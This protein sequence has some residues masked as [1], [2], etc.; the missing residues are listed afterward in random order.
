VETRI[1]LFSVGVTD[2][3]AI[4]AALLSSIGLGWNLYRDLRDKAKLKVTASVKRRV[5]CADGKHYA[6]S[7]HINVAGASDQLFVVI[8]VTNVGRRPVSWIGWGGKYCVPQNMKDSFV[9]IPIGLPRTL[10]EGEFHSEYTENLNTEMENVR[11]LFIWDASGR[12]WY[13]SRRKLKTLKAELQKLKLLL[14]ETEN[15]QLTDG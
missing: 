14:K 12:N 13:L 5:W 9:I 4:Y 6:V 8:D 2:I 1:I 15:T 3:L 10:Q 7:P 11:Q